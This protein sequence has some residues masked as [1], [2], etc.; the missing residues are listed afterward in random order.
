MSVGGIAGRN[1]G[2]IENNTIIDSV[3]ME[4]TINVVMGGKNQ[5]IYVGGLVGS[6]YGS[7]VGSYNT[8]DQASYTFNDIGFDSS[9][10][11]RVTGVSSNTRIGGVVGYNMGGIGNLAVQGEV[12]APNSDN[13]GGL[14]GY[15]TSGSFEY[16]IERSFMSGKTQGRN[17][18]GGAIG[19]ALQG[20][21]YNI[22]AENYAT[23]SNSSRTFVRG[24]TYVGG[25]IGYASGANIE[26]S[27]VVSYFN[28]DSLSEDVANLDS[29]YDVVGNNNVGGFIGMAANSCII[30]NSASYLNVKGG[31]GAVS[32]FISFDNNTTISN[33]FTIGCIYGEGSINTNPISTKTNSY[34]IL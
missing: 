11:I 2:V 3:N 15:N 17:Y 19:Q 26:F 9:L 23:F 33:S 13:V 1:Y 14:V 7:V 10:N 21:Y 27:Y 4:G 28:S 8:S 20:S 31:V 32:N 16:S 18:V 29:S 25:L 24:E 6:N 12:I 22:S 30:T 5:N 34:S